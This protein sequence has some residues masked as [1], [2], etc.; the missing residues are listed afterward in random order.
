M[1]EG[2][3]P[4]RAM[5]IP[6]QPFAEVQRPTVDPGANKQDDSMS[7]SPL[8]ERPGQIDT[9]LEEDP[10]MPAGDSATPS[11]LPPV[12]GGR[13]AWA[14]LLCATILETLVWGEFSGSGDVVPL[15]MFST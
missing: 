14:Y 1:R 10:Y 12:D 2:A 9:G 15:L 5:S 6:R 3:T 11:S 4:F 8:K 7:I 13:Q